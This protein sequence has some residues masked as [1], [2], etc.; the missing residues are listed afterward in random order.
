MSGQIVDDYFKS[1]KQKP[2]PDNGGGGL[3][4]KC[5]TC[6]GNGRNPHFIRAG[7]QNG[8][9]MVPMALCPTCHGKGQIPLIKPIIMGKK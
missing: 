8:N 5:P 7:V 2:K 6:G 1:Q 4:M 3:F 9:M